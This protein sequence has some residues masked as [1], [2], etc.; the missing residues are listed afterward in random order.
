MGK[1]QIKSQIFNLYFKLYIISFI[2]LAHHQKQC[3]TLELDCML[4]SSASTVRAVS[5]ALRVRIMAP[6]VA[7]S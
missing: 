4:I 1:S 7:K 6:H 3:D 2:D 5:R